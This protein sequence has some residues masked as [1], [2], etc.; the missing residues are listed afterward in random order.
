[1]LK[2]YLHLSMLF[3]ALTSCA[4]YQAKPLN[5]QPVLLNNVPHLVVHDS[6][7]PLPELAS[8]TFNPDDGLDMKEVAILAV[9]NNPDLKAVR[10]ERGVARAELIAAGILPNPQLTAG[11][12]HPTSGP[13][14]VN[15]FNLGLGYD[16]STLLTRKAGIDAARANSMS[17]DLTILWQEWQVVQKARVLFVESVEQEKQLRILQAF[18]DLMDAGYQRARRALKEGNITI[19]VVSADLAALQD[20]TT[21][22]HDLERQLAKTRQDLNSLLGISPDIKL[23]LTDGNDVPN[24]D[25]SDIAANLSLLPQHRP[26]LLA[27]QAGYTS[28]EERFRKAV[29]AQFPALSIGITRSRDTSNVYT[30]GFGITLSLPIFDRNQGTIA[31]EKAT[32]ERLYDEYQA[33]LNNAYSQVK[34]LL[35]QMR[36]VSK[37]YESVKS[38]LPDMEQTAER[39]KA[40]LDEGDLDITT[41]TGLQAAL[42][43]KRVEAITLEKTM[44]E[45]RIVLQTLLGNELPRGLVPAGIHLDERRN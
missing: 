39:A 29:L 20:A 21:N 6:Q 14:Y 26:D 16:I 17:I 18:R 9:V 37:Q 35:V 32:R 7:M 43:K 30:L 27:L 40:A 13:G 28:Q 34:G 36:L 42:L 1:M 45:Q 4:S 38:S 25:Q 24:P 19:D 15:A 8:H 3:V 31:I 33:R 12:D 44:L 5:T 22:L 2:R 23:D 41:Y 10:D 11:V